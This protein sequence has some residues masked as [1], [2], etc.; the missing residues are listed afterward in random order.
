MAKLW[1]NKTQLRKIHILK[2]HGLETLHKIIVKEHLPLI[3][4][5]KNS[6]IHV[7]ETG[8]LTQS[9]YEKLVE[10]GGEEAE[11]KHGEVLQLPFTME[12]GS[13]LHWEFDVKTLDVKFEVRFRTQGD[14]GAVEETVQASQKFGHGQVQSGSWTTSTTGTLVLVWDNASSWRRPKHLIYKTSITTE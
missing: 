4:G 3:L 11:I 6:L 10:L 14:G 2:E 9:S 7:P 1:F 5:G 12:S 8:Y 13:T